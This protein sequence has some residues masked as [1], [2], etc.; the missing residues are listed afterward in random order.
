MGNGE[1]SSE[2]PPIGLELTRTSTTRPRVLRLACVETN[3]GVVG[4]RGWVC[5]AVRIGLGASKLSGKQ[6]C[7]KMVRP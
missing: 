5:S 7:R 1:N 6:R 2:K 4:E 3:Q